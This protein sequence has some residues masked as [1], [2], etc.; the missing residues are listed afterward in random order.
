M[1]MERTDGG[2]ASAVVEN[3]AVRGARIDERLA[4]LLDR[5]LALHDDHLVRV[6]ADGVVHVAGA[7]HAALAPGALHVGGKRR[8][9]A[10]VDLLADALAG[11]APRVE[12]QHVPDVVEVGGDLLD[13]RHAARAQHSLSDSRPLDPVAR[14]APVAIQEPILRR[15]DLEL[16]YRHP[17]AAPDREER[18]HARKDRVFVNPEQPRPLAALPGDMPVVGAEIPVADRDGATAGTSLAVDDPQPLEVRLDWQFRV[19]NA[20]RFVIGRVPM[21]RHARAMPSADRD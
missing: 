15:V 16:L 9:V 20:A 3:H 14:I 10:G 17:A 11:F 6:H 1:G 19:G 2:D 18:R 7:G 4:D 5:A 21:P 8:R 12:R 13:R